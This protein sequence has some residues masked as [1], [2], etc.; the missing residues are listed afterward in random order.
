M[1]PQIAAEEHR[2]VPRDDFAPR[3]SR[4]AQALGEGGVGHHQRAPL[5]PQG[6]GHVDRRH[7]GGDNDGE[8]GEKAPIARERGAGEPRRLD[9]GEEVDREQDE[10][11]HVMGPQPGDFGAEDEDDDRARHDDERGADDPPVTR[12]W[13]FGAAQGGESLP[14]EQG[15][16]EDQR[17]GRIEEGGDDGAE[18]E[19]RGGERVRSTG[20]GE[21]GLDE[22]GERR[23]VVE[24]P[25]EVGKHDQGGDGDAEK[26]PGVHQA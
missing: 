14:E 10:H 7:G 16:E 20:E 13:R 2:K 23:R 15:E 19:D 9:A 17:H 21:F 12:R 3:K 1:D 11:D 18:S 4:L 6:L 22:R 8:G 26:G 5:A 24:V 25:N